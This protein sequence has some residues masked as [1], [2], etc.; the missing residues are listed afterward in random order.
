MPFNRWPLLLAAAG[1]I[2]ACATRP[3]PISPAELDEL[4]DRASREPL[5]GQV[6]L[7]YAAALGA[8]DRCDDAIPVAR[9][10]IERSPADALGPLVL[11]RCL[12]QANRYDEAIAAYRD[13][14][15]A[16][17]DGR[18]SGAV[19]ARE[20][21]AVRANAVA[22]ARDALARESELS[23]QPA[24]PQTV[25]VLPVQ[26]Q[27]D[28]MYHALSRGLA[29]M[30]TSDLSLLERFRMVERMRIGALLDEMQL[31]QG[32]QVDVTTAARVGRLTRAGRMVQ[33]LAAIP[34]EDNVRLEAS[35]VL[36]T[37]EVSGP[38]RAQGQLRD[39]L[40]MEKELVVGVAA[41][42]GYTLSEAERTA[43]L[44]NG[45]QNLSA[46]LAYSNALEAEDRADYAAA[47][48]Y[49]Q[50]AAQAD[51]S[52]RQ[53]RDGYSSSTAA[54]TAQSTSAADAPVL[55][56][57]EAPS[58]VSDSF[59]GGVLE[60]ATQDIAPTQA[61]IAGTI[62]G[63]PSPGVKPAT[64]PPAVVPPATIIGAIRIVFRLP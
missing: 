35:V 9:R 18:G 28:S 22:V 36:G 52:F 26:V 64:P 62:A 54:Q 24:D 27:G 7:R 37:G 61:E 15:A 44:E 46:F 19:R 55:A 47:A 6:Q 58:P 42:L 5:N 41:G 4:A 30:L 23:Q 63:P 40:R 16:R 29:Q 21:L 59:E 51:P 3:A 10:G 53:A 33:G 25:A 31:A 38:A 32:G 49:Y 45:T 39:L 13:F 8:A 11:G 43:I 14:L 57:E 56:R 17:P 60:G 34:D 2:W 1:S 50:A 12:E 48:R 20:Q